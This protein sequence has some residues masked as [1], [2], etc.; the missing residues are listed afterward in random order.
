MKNPTRDFVL[1]LVEKSL[2][3]VPKLVS[4]NAKLKLRVVELEKRLEFLWCLEAWGVDN[5][6]GYPDAVKDY[7]TRSDKSDS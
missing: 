4:E 3:Q 1:G 7:E 6:V 2:N 5:W